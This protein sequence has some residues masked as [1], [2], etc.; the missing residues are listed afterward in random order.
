MV[1][2]CQS[3][4]T[5]M[6]HTTPPVT[7]SKASHESRNHKSHGNEKR[8]VP[9]MLPS[10]NRTFAKVGNVGNT[11]L[12]AW[13]DKHPPD[14]GPK[15]TMVGT[16]RIEL[17]IGVPMM[18]TMTTG[19]PLDRPLN[20]ACTCDSEDVLQGLGRIV[21]PVGP[22]TMIACGNTWRMVSL[23]VA[24]MARIQTYQAQ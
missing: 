1:D 4:G 2:K 9:P 7:P 14:V 22:E 3:Q 15:Q 6:E 19:P 13:L 16:I 10:N 24:I 11:R 17:S 8:N 23:L 5:G 18:G 20:G 12:A 21:G